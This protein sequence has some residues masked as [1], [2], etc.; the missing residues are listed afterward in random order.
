MCFIAVQNERQPRNT[1]TI[2]AP[3]GVELNEQ[4]LREYAGAVTTTVGIMSTHSIINNNNNNSTTTTTAAA[5]TDNSPISFDMCHNDND[6]EEKN[7]SP[8]SST[9]A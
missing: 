2:R 4:L 9:G 8:S 3:I 5:A 1:A 7:Q 6:N